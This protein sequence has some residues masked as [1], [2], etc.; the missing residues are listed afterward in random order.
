MSE[1]LGE[2]TSSDVS[3]Q[4]NHQM[5]QTTACNKVSPG[6]ENMKGLKVK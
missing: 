2:Y 6:D 1:I 5:F 4:V 3:Q